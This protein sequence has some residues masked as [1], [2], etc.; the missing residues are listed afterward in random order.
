M[1]IKVAILLPSLLLAACHQGFVADHSLKSAWSQEL[2]DTQPSKIPYALIYNVRGKKLIYVA[3]ASDQRHQS[4][5]IIESLIERNQPKVVLI[6]GYEEGIRVNPSKVQFQLRN[7]R[8]PLKGA[9]ASREDILDHLSG[10]GIS[11]RDYV[12]FQALNL[13]NQ[14]WQFETDSPQELKMRV[15]HYLQTDPYAKKYRLTYE[16]VKKWFYEKVK[17]PLTDEMLVDGELVAPKNPKLK[18]TTLLQKM[19]TYEDQLDDEVALDTLSDELDEQD[20]VMIIRAPSK[21]VTERQVLHKML[22]VSQP[23]EIVN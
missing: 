6:Q 13:A 1:K 19:S 7:Y 4:N 23:S 8:P 18:S 17:L 22:G 16:D 15:T 3:A 9:S 2:E 5:I 10:Y 20:V 12:I 14:R 11:E 21:F